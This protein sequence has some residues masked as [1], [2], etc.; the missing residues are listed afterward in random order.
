MLKAES[1]EVEPHTHEAFS[2]RPEE[3]WA[4]VVLPGEGS[5]ILNSQ[6]SPVQQMKEQHAES[7]RSSRRNC[8]SWI[9]P[10]PEYRT[11]KK[12][13]EYSLSLTINQI[14]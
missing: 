6:P 2:A 4:D 13:K 5:D 12:H 8:H 11:V 1:S 10:E 3:I 14:L 7:R 9:G